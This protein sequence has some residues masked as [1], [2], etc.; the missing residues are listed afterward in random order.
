[1]AEG[2]MVAIKTCVCSS[3]YQDETYGGGRRVHNRTKQNNP[4]SQRSWRCT[5]CGKEKS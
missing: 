1:M 3:R 5:V 4:E 2:T